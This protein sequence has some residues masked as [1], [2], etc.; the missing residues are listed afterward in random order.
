MFINDCG[1]CYEDQGSGGTTLLQSCFLSG[2][3][4]Y[5]IEITGSLRQ[6]H[7][8]SCNVESSPTG[9]FSGAASSGVG[10]LL[11]SDCHF[12][13]NVDSDMRLGNGTHNVIINGGRYSGANSVTG[14]PINHVGSASGGPF[15]IHLNGP[16]FVDNGAG[17]NTI[18]VSAGIDCNVLIPTLGGLLKGFDPSANLS[19]GSSDSQLVIPSTIGKAQPNITHV[20]SG[21]LEI[22]WSLGTIVQVDLEAD[23]TNLTCINPVEGA[24][25]TVRFAQDSAGGHTVAFSSTSFDSDGGFKVTGSPNNTTSTMWQRISSTK[26]EIITGDRTGSTATTSQLNNIGHAI[27]T[28]G[29]YL[30]KQ[31]YNT[32]TK[33][34]VAADGPLAGDVWTDS[35]GTTYT[36]VI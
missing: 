1:V 31:A 29:K 34:M 4:T 22:D 13:G 33:R 11:L 7:L 25:H 3:L 6:L 28:S 19:L 18:I 8:S 15:N 24:L 23:I 16:E 35:D 14:V 10:T 26:V 36:P 21:P 12:E 30:G 9:L 27:N 20:A 17:S 2:A 5:A 32:N